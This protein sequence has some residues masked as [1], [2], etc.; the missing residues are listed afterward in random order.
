MLLKEHYRTLKKIGQ[1]GYCQTFL[2]VDEG[3]YPPISC[4]IQKFDLQ[5]Q[6]VDEFWQKAKFIQELSA[7]PQI[8]CLL[9]KFIENNHFYLMYEYISG[10]NLV[11]FLAEL[12]IFSEIK[13]WRLLENILPILSY[14][15]SHNMIHGD[16]KPENIIYNNQNLFLVDFSNLQ[17]IGRQQKSE[18]LLGTPGYFAPEQADGKALFCSDLYSL[19]V[20]CIYLLTNVHPFQLYDIANQSWVWRQYL[21]QDISTRLGNILDKLIENNS[22]LRFQSAAEVMQF[23]GM[24]NF[25]SLAVKKQTLKTELYTFNL[26]PALASGINTVSIWENPTKNITIATG[27]D[28]KTIKLWDFH[29]KKLI[30]TLSGHSQAVTSVAFSPNAK[31]LA[32]A[33]D[34]KKIKLWDVDTFGEIYTLS[35]HS[36]FVKSVAFSPSGEVLASASWDKTI[37]IWDVKTGNLL[38]TLAGHKL[39]VSALAFSP[40]G[41]LL[42][43]AS[44]D[45][46]ARLWEIEGESLTLVG[47]IWAVLTVAFSPD[48]RILA[49]GSDDNTIKLWNVNT[50]DMVASLE[51]HSWSVLSL[52]FSGDGEYLV[53]ASRD[54]TVKLWDVKQQAE[55]QTFCG[56]TDSVSV[57]T[58][59]MNKVIISG[60]KDKTI[61]VWDI[62]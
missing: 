57:V 56:H 50:G 20:T 8:P 18:N 59:T 39:Q 1:G 13:V 34:D 51:G 53:S 28:D 38:A 44:F 31:Y 35:G 60:S 27:C 9:D 47:H 40:Q 62:R 54:K 6:K 21:T 7:H 15:H 32:S 43:S 2:A 22:E 23:M 5:N 58:M 29:T 12:E 16:I 49:T 25:T 19:G 36:N 24:A 48:G 10:K 3:Q 37:K 41:N 52:A 33:S 55:I 26:S 42:A 30:R 61:K 4:V 11:S 46:T 14:I 45:R 17:I